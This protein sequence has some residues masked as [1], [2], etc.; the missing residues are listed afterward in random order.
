MGRKLNAEAKAMDN[1]ASAALID[2][3]AKLDE[4]A[5]EQQ[6]DSAAKQVGI[7][8]AKLDKF[9]RA[10]RRETK[11]SAAAPADGPDLVDTAT[12]AH[13]EAAR[14]LMQQV[15]ILGA[16]GKVVENSGLVGE[17]NNAKII[18]LALTS[19]LFERPVSIVIKG[20]SAG[21]KSITVERVLKF[22]PRSAFFERT[23]MSER[24]V[25]YSDEDFRNRFIVIFEAVGMNSDVMSYLIRTLLSEGR[26]AYEV[27]E[28][29][30]E[31]LRPRRIEKEGPTG[32]VTTTTQARLHPENETRMMSLGV[33]DTRDQTKAVMRSVAADTP[34]EV[35][36]TPWHLVQVELAKSGENVS[37]PFADHL[38]QLIPPVAVRLRRDFRL[39]LTLIRA[40]ALL[41]RETRGRDVEK[42]IV[43]TLTD[44]AAVRALVAKLFAEGVEATVSAAI[45]ETVEAVG[46]LKRAST[47][48]FNG[49]TLPGNT[50]EVSLTDLA[51]QLGVDKSSASHRVKKAISRGFLVNREEKKGKPARI[52]LV[53]DMPTEQEILPTPEQLRECCSVA[54]VSGGIKSKS[55]AGEKTQENGGLDLGAQ[56]TLYTPENDCNTA[57]LTQIPPKCT[58]CGG[59][60]G[61]PPTLYRGA[62]YPPEGVLLHR[63]CV[64]FWLQEHHMGGQSNGGSGAPEDQ[65]QQGMPS[66]ITRLMRERLR[67]AG[68]SADAIHN[69][70]PGQAH[71]ALTRPSDHESRE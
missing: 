66:M 54:V 11:K 41:H 35:D 64:R 18:Y 28:K 38:A 52:A 69:M 34:N 9:V 21:G 13:K 7:R 51:K 42:R 49:S 2:K 53:G 8:A 5:Y 26:V 27:V 50:F 14:E 63:E 20:V 4:M 19:R 65:T 30:S 15:D 25:I 56:R 45:R 10:K 22:F 61:T 37:I 48:E 1:V 33:I 46:A 23:G 62:D 43:A 17:T 40:H 6:R 55:H 60:E 58:Q 31:G 70:T 36:Y 16:V 71:E 3:L 24:A 29:T 12:P 44:Y 39:L 59:D 57:T 32:L 67:S 68:Y 47:V